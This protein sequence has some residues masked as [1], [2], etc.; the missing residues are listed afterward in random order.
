MP[1]FP[2]SRQ[3]KK[4]SHRGSITARMVANLLH[5]AG[6]N[7]VI[8]LDLHASQMQGFF[9]CPVDNLVA[10][11]LLA[12]WI[13]GNIREWKKAVVVSKNPGGT[14]RVTSLADALKLNFG[15]VMTDRT[16]PGSGHASMMNSMILEKTDSNGVDGNYEDQ[17]ETFSSHANGNGVPDG[18]TLETTA[19]SQLPVQPSTP[20]RRTA[21]ANYEFQASPLRYEHS[22][23]ESS[24]N[25]LSRVQT[26][27]SATRDDLDGSADEADDEDPVSMHARSLAERVLTSKQCARDI[28]TGR[29]RH[30]HII[31]D[32]EEAPSPSHSA[33]DSL[34]RH[35]LDEDHIPEHMISST[36]STTSSVR[37]SAPS[38]GNGN[39][40]GGSGDA[41]ASSDDEEENLRNPDMESTVTLVGNVKDRAV[42]ILDDMID[43]S[44]SWIAAAETVVKRGG[45][46]TV[47]C[48][49]THGCVLFSLLPPYPFFCL[50]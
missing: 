40:L 20:R 22:V 3:S 44:A 8:T 48:F 42:F 16:R 34:D 39:G 33:Y 1:Y 9:H 2:Y 32:D 35:L 21:T 41:H 4:K 5:E 46:T 15:I 7:H 36:Y 10:E 37:N 38:N 12:Q 43:K 29:L 45:A 26:A 19:S 28:I 23:A 47:Y 6:V 11:P 50:R 25:S 31:D 27:P 14:K 13:K 18:H 49:A 24:S 17:I 30:G